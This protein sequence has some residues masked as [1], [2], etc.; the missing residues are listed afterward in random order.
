MEL[1][2]QAY[3]RGW[4]ARYCKLC[5]R[6]LPFLVINQ[7]SRDSIHFIPISKDNVLLA[8]CD[9]CG[10]IEAVKPTI[11]WQE[12]WKPEDGLQKLVDATNPNVGKLVNDPVPTDT[13][14]KA[15]LNVIA[16][17][18]DATD[19]FKFQG[20]AISLGLTGL[21]I[22]AIGGVSIAYVASKSMADYGVLG[23]FLGGLFGAALGI[24]LLTQCFIPQS[25]ITI[26]I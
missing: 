23:G 21:V 10:N 26:W 13:Q 18:A 12:T 6:L 2:V 16:R 4:T 5:D 9:F 3:A 20:R 14:L 22:S 1:N 24:A 7:I 25:C 8:V 15:L 11:I 19:K 17:R